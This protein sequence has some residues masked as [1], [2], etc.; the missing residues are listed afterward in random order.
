MKYRIAYNKYTAMDD[1]GEMLNE[2]LHQK[3]KSN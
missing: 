3:L 2:H 1:K